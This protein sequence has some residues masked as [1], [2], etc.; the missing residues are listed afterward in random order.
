MNH[1]EIA[2]MLDRLEINGIRLWQEDGKLKYSAP[3]GALTSEIRSVLKQ[4]KADIIDFLKKDAEEVAVVHDE[5]NRY[6]PFPLTDIQSA[7]LIGRNEAFA[8]SGVACHIYM[9]FHYEN[10]EPQRAE[11]IWNLMIKRHDSLRTCFRADGTQVVLPSVGR[12]RIDYADVSEKGK[13]A[14]SERIE[15]VRAELGHCIHAADNPPLMALAIT[16]TDCDAI[17][18]LSMDFIMADWTSIRLLLA[19]FEGMYFYGDGVLPEFEV[20][21]RDYL[22]S[23]ALLKEKS[24][25]YKDKKYW[26]DKID[27]LPAAPDIAVKRSSAADSKLFKRLYLNLEPERWDKLKSFAAKFGLTPSSAVLASYA[28]VLHWWSSTDKFS[29]NLTVLNRFPLHEQVNSLIG[30]FTSVSLLECDFTDSASFAQSARK[31]NARLFDDLDHRLYSGVMVMREI[32]RRK[33]REAALMPFVYTSSIGVIQEDPARPMVGRFDGEGISQTPQV[34]LDCQAMDGSFGL[35]VNWD[36]RDG[37]FHENVIE[38]MFAAF[39][40]LLEM[41][42]DSAEIWSSDIPPILPKYQ[43]EMIAQSNSTNVQLPGGLLHSGLLDSIR[44][45]PDKLA[46][47]DESKSFTYG[48]LGLLASAVKLQLI[49]TGC[50]KGDTVGIVM[51]KSV[52]QISS[53]VGILDAQ[54]VYVPIDVHQAPLRRE[55][56][57]TQ[58]GI[59]VIITLRAYEDMFN[60]DAYKLIFA[61]ELTPAPSLSL[62]GEGDESALAYIIYTSGSTGTPKGVAIRH[63]AAV[64]TIEDINSR[65]DVT[66]DDAVLG[67]S[68]LNFDLSVYDIFGVLGVGGSVIYPS[69]AKY[70]DPSHWMEL[71][72][73][74]KITLW[75]SVPAFIQMFTDYI[76]SSSEKV[77]PHMRLVMMSGDWIPVTLPERIW[78]LNPDVLTVSLGGATEASIWSIYHICREIK[79]E[80]NSIPYGKP[81]ANQ[82]YHVL[83]GKLRERPF[84]VQG[85]LYI[86]GVG[87]A[88]CYYKQDELTS[89]AFITVNG[90]RMYKTGDTG[91]WMSD[92]EIEFMGRN[93]GQLKIHGHRIELG[94]IDNCIIQTG[95]V[96]CC[97]LAIGTPTGEKTLIS[98]YCAESESDASA[99]KE[100]LK[101]SLPVY[102]I[103]SIIKYKESL[104]LTANG[105][106]DRKKLSA[107]AE[108]LLKDKLS[109]HIEDETLTPSE[110]QV[111]DICSELL[112]INS[113]GKND[114]LY[115]KGAD[116]LM[117][118]KA[119]GIIREKLLP[120]VS[121]DSI[122]AQLL[123]GPS[124]REIAEFI[125]SQNSGTETSSD[126]EDTPQSDSFAV[127]KA[128]P[129]ASDKIAVLLWDENGADTLMQPLADK[130]S[131]SFGI[132]QLLP[133]NLDNLKEKSAED[134]LQV[135]TDSC[136]EAIKHY[137]D[138]DITIFAHGS[139]SWFGIELAGRLTAAEYPLDKLVL[140][141][142][143]PSDESDEALDEY[144]RLAAA[145]SAAEPGLYMGDMLLLY[146][147]GAESAEAYWSSACLG[148]F[149]SKHISGAHTSCLS[150][151]ADAIISATN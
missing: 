31:L 109:E 59:S 106:V 11:D 92:G 140:I 116:S 10:L 33:G 40:S 85:D 49:N 151:Q 47:A 115:S 69:A 102:M 96:Q 38:D 147:D 62:T 87:L 90:T 98:F 122:L 5:D 148:S 93:D 108:T 73:K 46:A 48:E 21:F 91:R 131:G 139:S 61:D 76:E 60:S 75:N 114:D 32:A 138:K 145:V 112:R 119:A 135:V 26:L 123:R 9:E 35:Q 4:Q 18:H 15:T 130:L 41:L 45:T 14:K 43:A 63:S 121:F 58:C 125:D 94:E 124:I 67:L 120:S 12:L 30:D 56:I 70:A 113:I 3:Q 129:A 53:A 39:K 29:L 89:D 79:R 103:P 110:Q 50:S 64:N 23:E 2:G 84:W 118:G 1:N 146:T 20:S 97:T 13:N 52:Y 86:T 149:D 66:A 55:K 132:A 34:Y 8:L 77:L 72:K 136:V 127:L 100:K 141:D 143:L 17:L 137:S 54:C 71:V 6:Q 104:P 68:Q 22:T 19:E 150:E 80:W 111:F 81:L 99:I 27:T 37:I 142:A 42:S 7:Y 83:D 74:Y 107:E 82:G 36:Y 101:D 78:A 24:G 25:F 16:K 134:A 95:A 51:P 133:C 126:S 128:S 65:F 44:R 28:Q 117:I 105:K 88:D 144:K 57:L